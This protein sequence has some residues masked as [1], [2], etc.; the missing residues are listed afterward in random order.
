M[1]RNGI[2]SQS[3][4]FNF[5][6]QTSP[7]PWNC[8]NQFINITPP[9]V[10]IPPPGKMKTVF[11][12]EL[13]AGYTEN[14][15]SIKN[16]LN[17]YWNTYPQEFIKCPIID[18]QGSLEITLQL[19]NEYYN[20]GYRYFVGFS[21][22][23]IVNG[24]LEWFNKYIDA[25]GISATS[26]AASLNIPKNIFRMTP[27]DNYMIDSITQ[28]LEGKIVNYIYSS[29]EYAATDLIAYIENI[30]NITLNLYPIANNSDLDA[31]TSLNTGHTDEIMLCYII[32][33]PSRQYYL[34]LFLDSNPVLTYTNTQY[35][36]LG[37]TT[38]I[39]TNSS[40]LNNNY[41]T[42]T[43]LINLLPFKESIMA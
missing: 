15:V 8:I 1:L 34:D 20:L 35:D 24:V 28:F 32:A 43:Q 23:T 36:I 14:D 9:P 38:P 12:L 26:T 10:I 27:N 17:Y 11:L 22:S 5:C 2:G 16:T 31:L 21:R 29:N 30:S 42:T 25:T 4:M 37:T 40:V 41:N 6:K 19:L 33:N 7:Q 3:R 18:T 13:T 39:I